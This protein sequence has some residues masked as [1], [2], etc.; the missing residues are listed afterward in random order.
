ML[1]I[2]SD[3]NIVKASSTLSWSSSQAIVP[4]KIDNFKVGK[5]RKSD[6]KVLSFL[7]WIVNKLR[8][9]IWYLYTEIENQKVKPKCNYS[10]YIF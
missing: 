3:K 1:V 7:K 2:D 6:D 4:F 5:E 10:H 9:E 8:L